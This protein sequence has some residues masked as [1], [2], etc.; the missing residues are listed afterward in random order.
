MTGR[1]RTCLCGRVGCE[2]HGGKVWKGGERYQ[3]GSDPAFAVLRDRMLAQ[4]KANPEA[5]RCGIC[6]EPARDGDP[7]QAY[8]IVPASRG[9]APT[10][11]N[12]ALA[13]VSC[14]RR[15]GSRLGAERSAERRRAKGIQQSESTAPDKDPGDG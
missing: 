7:W 2:R 5:V 4:A 3:R 14:S 10:I 6:W 12:L 15:R 8:H 11:D 1:S 13:H 9:G